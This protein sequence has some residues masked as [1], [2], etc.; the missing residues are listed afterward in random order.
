MEDNLEIEIYKT[1]DGDCPYLRWEKDLEETIRARL[2]SRLNRIILGNFG[3]S[4]Y[5]KNGINELR[6]HVGP[7]YRIYFG[8]SGRKVVLLLCGGDKDSQTSDIKRA[9]DYWNDYKKNRIT[10]WQNQ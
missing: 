8:K 3:D 10:T 7:G 1:D 2:S 6:I 5:L 4:K 9:I